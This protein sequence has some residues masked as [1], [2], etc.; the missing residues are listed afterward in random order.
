MSKPGRELLGT[1][2]H[3]V[4]DYKDLNKI[5]RTPEEAAAEELGMVD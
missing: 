2:K 3:D 1:K 5:E 4:Y